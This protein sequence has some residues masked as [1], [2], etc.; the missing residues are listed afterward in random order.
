MKFMHNTILHYSNCFWVS[1]TYATH[2]YNNHTKL[3]NHQ[4]Y[5]YLLLILIL[6]DNQWHTSNITYITY[7]VHYSFVITAYM[8]PVICIIK[9]ADYNLYIIMTI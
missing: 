2:I 3:F 9:L 1:C 4:L 6:A 7:A 5:Y 8:R